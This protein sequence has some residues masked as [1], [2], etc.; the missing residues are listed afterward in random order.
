MPILKYKSKT[1]KKIYGG[2]IYDCS[3]FKIIIDIYYTIFV[4]IFTKYLYLNINL[5][6]VKIL[7]R[8]LLAYN[9]LKKS[10]GGSI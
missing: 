4:C 10:I 5:K 8:Y 1:Y 6:I 9:L 7:L 3:Y 2:H